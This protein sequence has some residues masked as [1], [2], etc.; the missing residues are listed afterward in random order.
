VL[1]LDIFKMSIESQFNQKFLKAF[2]SLNLNEYLN[3]EVKEF[4]ENFH[5]FA[6]ISEKPNKN[7]TD[8]TNNHF[9]LTLNDVRQLM[10][11]HFIGKLLDK[12]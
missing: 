11:V 1:I 6:E 12:K 9:N 8:Q 5:V 3:E 4:G 7:N 2:E 10:I